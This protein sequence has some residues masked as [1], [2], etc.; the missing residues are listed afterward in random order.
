VDLSGFKAPNMDLSGFKAPNIDLS[1]FKAPNIGLS[2]FKPSIN[3][4]GFKTPSIFKRSKPAIEDDFFS[5]YSK[6]PNTQNLLE[7]LTRNPPAKPLIIVRDEES[8]G[9]EEE[10]TEE[11]E[12]TSP[13]PEKG[14]ES[15][16]VPVPEPEKGPAPEPVPEPVPE[17]EKGPD[18]EGEVVKNKPKSRM[19]RMKDYLKKFFTTKKLVP[20]PSSNTV[21]APSS[22]SLPA[23]ELIPESVNRVEREIMSPEDKLDQIKLSFTNKGNSCFISVILK[24]LW[25]MKPIRQFFINLPLE[26]LTLTEYEDKKIPDLDKSKRVIHYLHGVFQYIRSEIIKTTADKN[27]VII[28]IDAVGEKYPGCFLWN[29]MRKATLAEIELEEE[30]MT[31]DFL[32]SGIDESEK[33]KKNRQRRQEDATTLLQG[34]LDDFTYFK[35][36]NSFSECFIINQTSN[37]AWKL[38]EYHISMISLTEKTEYLADSFHMSLEYKDGN[39][40]YIYGIPTV[41]KYLIIS[42][43]TKCVRRISPELHFFGSLYKLISSISHLGR[44]AQG[45]YVY[46][47]YEYSTIPGHEATIA[48]KMYDD[49]SRTGYTDDINVLNREQYKPKESVVFLYERFV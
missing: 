46:L 12:D 4:S 49:L 21:L 8:E 13:V 26:H 45:H 37:N 18:P 15:E 5:F 29:Y 27:Q 10:K 44:D 42:N 20:V 41:N 1:G 2:K 17:S 30:K 32:E 19:T 11:E 48:N 47:D 22:K 23:H 9:G 6:K 25:D 36:L 34:I 7:Q 35:E 40:Q 24:L 16:S 14:T 33:A 43:H 31:H 39:V 28:D 3:F 38:N